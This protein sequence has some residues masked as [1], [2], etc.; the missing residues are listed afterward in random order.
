MPRYFFHTEDGVRVVDREG[1]Q[2]A[3]LNAARIEALRQ[4]CRMLNDQAEDFWRDPYW[5]LSAENEH[6]TTLFC[7]EISATLAPAA[8]F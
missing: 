7:I 1:A 2:C 5:K 4:A 8:R 3:D 6:G